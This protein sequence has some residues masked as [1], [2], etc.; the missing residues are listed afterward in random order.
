MCKD[1]IISVS[2]IQPSQTLEKD[3]GVLKHSGLD[4][5][6]VCHRCKYEPV[7]KDRLKKITKDIPTFQLRA[8]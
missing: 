5:R 3:Q 2:V 7:R 6:F 1:L 4:Y 8:V